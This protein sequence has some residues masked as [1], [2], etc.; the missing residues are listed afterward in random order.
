M[1]FFKLGDYACFYDLFSYYLF[2]RFIYIFHTSETGVVIGPSRQR[3]HSVTTP[4]VV[5]ALTSPVSV[6][7]STYGKCFV[8]S[9]SSSPTSNNV[10]SSSS[11]SPS[12]ISSISTTNSST[13]LTSSDVVHHNTSS[14]TRHQL[15]QQHRL[16]LQHQNQRNHHENLQT[17]SEMH[18]GTNSSSIGTN[19][20]KAGMLGVSIIPK[21]PSSSSIGVGGGGEGGC[22]N[23]I[24]KPSSRSVYLSLSNVPKGKTFR[25]FPTAVTPV[26]ISTSS[27]SSSTTTSRILPPPL[28]S[29]TSCSAATNSVKLISS[30]TACLACIDTFFFLFCIYITFSFFTL[31][32]V[33][34]KRCITA[35]K[36]LTLQNYV[37][38]SFRTHDVSS[39]IYIKLCQMFRFV[40]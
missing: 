27:S 8:E 6:G 14:A 9:P 24:S 15:H 32:A 7:G 26:S 33:Y 19:S 10:K 23:S 40:V 5:S 21:S 18:H 1:I 20:L 17:S 3:F 13:P 28:L 36:N 22:L 29:P 11:N 37:Y 2:F 39:V 30:T 16:I 31:Y 35:L 4:P 34:A 25:N 38:S 12:S